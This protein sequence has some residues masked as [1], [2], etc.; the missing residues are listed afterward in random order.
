[1]QVR[2]LRDGDAGEAENRKALFVGQVYD[3]P[4]AL[5][6]PLIVSGAVEAVESEPQAVDSPPR[7][8]R[9]VQRDK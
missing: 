3:L 7:A 1:M 2:A 8:P 4:V 6:E 9:R 5:A